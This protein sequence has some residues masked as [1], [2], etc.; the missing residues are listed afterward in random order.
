MSNGYKF[1]KKETYHFA[2]TDEEFR[3]PI[4]QR[5][6]ANPRITEK[7]LLMIVDTLNKMHGLS[8]DW[9]NDDVDTY[10]LK[11]VNIDNN[12][13]YMLRY[14]NPEGLRYA[15]TDCIS[16]RELYSVLQGL[17]ARIEKER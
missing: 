3:S 12:K 16:R 15:L 14:H 8:T 10:R 6:Y 11:I 1:V 13:S 2:K 9:H 5:I 4:R 17:T 7:D